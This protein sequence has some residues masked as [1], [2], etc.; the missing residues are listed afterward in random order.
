MIP[1]LPNVRSCLPPTVSRASSESGGA[2]APAR[3]M[4]P[5]LSRVNDVTRRLRPARATCATPS[6]AK[7]G[8]SAPSGR[9]RTMAARSEPL[10]VTSVPA[11]S[12]EPDGPWRTPMAPAPMPL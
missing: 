5:A 4:R 9:S 7:C 3:T 11:T 1:P 12:T 2:P 6:A 10:A 8:S